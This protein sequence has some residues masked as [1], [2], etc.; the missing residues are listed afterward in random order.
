ML[1]SQHLLKVFCSCSVVN[2]Q[3]LHKSTFISATQS[4]S[5]S[6]TV[7]WLDIPMFHFRSL[8]YCPCGNTCPSIF[9]FVFSMTYLCLWKHT[10]L[11]MITNYLRKYRKLIFKPSLKLYITLFLILHNSLIHCF[12]QSCFFF[13]FFFHVSICLKNVL[14]VISGI[15]YKIWCGGVSSPSC[16]WWKP[17]GND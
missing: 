1:F 17:G 7:R 5:A 16:S 10:Q 12:T 11:I 15:R 9:C 14:P 8:Y 4:Q 13:C 6:W 3:I 2:M